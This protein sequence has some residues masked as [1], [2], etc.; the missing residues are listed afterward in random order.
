MYVVD[1]ATQ[2]EMFFGNYGAFIVVPIMS[3]IT[4]V[5]CYCWYNLI[6][7]EGW[8]YFKKMWLREQAA[9]Y[10]AG[11]R[12]GSHNRMFV[13]NITADEEYAAA[14]MALAVKE[15]GGIGVRDQ[16]NPFPEY[17]G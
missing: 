17:G 10:V 9:K 3:F 12:V 4:L 1:Q 2:T 5:H 13:G 14:A 6:I 8:F 16:W 7:G 15:S 11:V